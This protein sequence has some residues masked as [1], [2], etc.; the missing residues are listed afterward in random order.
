[1]AQPL[2]F[3]AQPCAQPIAQPIAQPLAIHVAVRVAGDVAG[4]VYGCVTNGCAKV[5]D[6]RV[7][8]G[9][10]KRWRVGVVSWRGLRGPALSDT[11]CVEAKGEALAIVYKE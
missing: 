1:M 7:A 8:G 4:D 6:K 9:L 10:S 3:P 11:L 2:R 5:C